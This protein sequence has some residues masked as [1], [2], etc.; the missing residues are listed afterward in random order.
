MK[1]KAVLLFAAFFLFAA[2]AQG[3]AESRKNLISSEKLH[4]LVDD[5]FFVNIIDLR[6]KEQYDKGH[7]P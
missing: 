5:S 2:L 7:I 4:T 1:K 3:M 6:S